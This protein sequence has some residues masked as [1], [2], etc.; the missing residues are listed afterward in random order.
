MEDFVEIAVPLT[1]FL[2][3][4]ILAV[5]L[6]WR[7]REHARPKDEPPEK[8]VLRKASRSQR[9]IL[10]KLEPIP[11]LPTVMDLMRQEI[12]ETGVESIPGHEGLAGP[13][14]LKVFRRDQQIRE[15]CT[16]DAIAFVVTDGIEPA[17]A[18]EANVSLYCDQCGD[19]PPE[20]PEEEAR[21][22][23]LGTESDSE[24]L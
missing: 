13:V 20:P 12:A 1:A 3:A 8:A 9:K 16:H 21:A 24:T 5:Y 19:L 18:T 10:E 7:A 15:R 6:L 2:G 23:D 11:E 22:E 14:M 4:I 17:A